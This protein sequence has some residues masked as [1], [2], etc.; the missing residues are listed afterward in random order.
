MNKTNVFLSLLAVFC[1]AT[2]VVQA[3]Q[4]ADTACSICLE[5]EPTNPVTTTCRHTFCSLCIAE[6]KKTSP[7]CPICKS[8]SLA[9]LAIVPTAAKTVA[10]GVTAANR[11]TKLAAA[12]EKLDTL[13]EIHEADLWDLD[14][15]DLHIVATR[16]QANNLMDS[17]NAAMRLMANLRNEEPAPAAVRPAAVAPRPAAPAYG[18]AVGVA[19][20]DEIPADILALSLATADARAAEEAQMRAVMA[21]SARLHTEGQRARIM[22]EEAEMATHLE[23]TR[24]AYEEEQL[25]RAREEA[26]LQEVMARSQRTGVRQYPGYGYGAAVAAPAPA[27]VGWNCPVCATSNKPDADCCIE[28]ISS[29]NIVNRPAR[30]VAVTATAVPAPRP[31]PMPVPA[32]R[33]VTGGAAGGYGVPVDP[34]AQALQR[35]QATARATGQRACQVCTFIN[36]IDCE[37]CQTCC[38]PL[39][40]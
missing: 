29:G 30:T 23:R 20:D 40:E 21:E 11:A 10:P 14:A 12:L 5:D 27:P 13:T 1:M 16:A 35:A 25:A 4:P 3:A 37:F 33:V 32:P 7:L 24:R 17:V 26:E 39:F 15:D 36:P 22:R 19:D 8:P 28:C 2:S 38:S 18:Y 6:W 9:A 31:M 34:V